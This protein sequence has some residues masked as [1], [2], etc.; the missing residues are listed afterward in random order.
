MEKLSP[1]VLESFGINSRSIRKEKGCHI[2]DTGGGL[3][4]INISYES[5]DAI[6]L[7]HSQ[8]EHIAAEGFPWVDRYRVANTGQPFCLIGRDTYIATA[9]PKHQQ[10]L[11]FENERS[12]INA[13]ET[14]AR[15]HTAARSMPQKDTPASQPLP[16]IYI[17]QLAELAQAGKQARRGPRMSDFDVA[18]IKHAAP[19]T[20]TIQNAIDC[21]TKT[22]YL[23]LYANAIGQNS[24]CHNALKEENMPEAGNSMY[25]IN[26]SKAT[27]DLQ[28]NDL[29]A[30][31]RRY[32][33]R[34]S[35]SL[36]INRLI[37][38]YGSISPLP[39]EGEKIL[40][41]QLVFPWA[42]M[43]IVG[44]YYS[45]KRNW[46]PNGLLNRLDAI[47]A[48]KENYEKYIVM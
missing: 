46:T 16:D 41:A 20:E 27:I 34:S 25:I 4:K 23:E 42:F 11:D 48:E 32:A 7:Q 30:L 13:F 6:C 10:E 8:K 28:L 2:V 19:A 29:A 15:F 9:Y 14:L 22:C 35:K 37:K 47:L 45:K 39:N 33:Q 40:H 12:V 1:V 24:L 31:I 43:K 44:Q 17:R 26:F 38:A 18:F 3:V 5:T 21:L 36:P